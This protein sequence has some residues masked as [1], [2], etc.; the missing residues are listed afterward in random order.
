MGIGAGLNLQTAMEWYQ[1]AGRRN[2]TPS[3]EDKGLDYY[4][5]CV[6]RVYHYGIKTNR[7]IPRAKEYYRKALELGWEPAREMLQI[8]S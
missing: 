4:Y 7:D 2:Y 1:M 5:Y 3:K 6:A 8:M